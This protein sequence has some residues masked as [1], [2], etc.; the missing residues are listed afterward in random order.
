MHT[1]Y[2]WSKIPRKVLLVFNCFYT[3]IKSRRELGKNFRQFKNNILEMRLI[4]FNGFHPTRRDFSHIYSVI[5]LADYCSDFNENFFL[6]KYYLEADIWRFLDS[7]K[8]LTTRCDLIRRTND[9]HA[10][11]VVGACLFS[12]YSMN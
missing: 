2:E 8:V 9:K 1:K 10:F 6:Q 12:C 4:R 5:S 7:W 11:V 3:I